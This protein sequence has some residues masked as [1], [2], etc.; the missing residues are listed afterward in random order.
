MN[1]KVSSKGITEKQHILYRQLHVE[2]AEEVH[3]Y[4]TRREVLLDCLPP[5]SKFG[6][7]HANL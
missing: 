7:Q 6:F 1:A 2:D 5:V 4:L 3:A